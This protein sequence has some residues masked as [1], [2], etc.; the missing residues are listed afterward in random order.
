MLPSF[1]YLR[2]TSLDEAVRQ[3]ALPGA[4]AHAGGTDLLG[5]LR[6]R[7]LAAERVVS[8]SAIAALRG[9]SP[10]A[11]GGLRI[12]ALVTLAELAADARIG[13]RYPTL[14]HAAAA[15]ASPQLRNQGT[16]GGNL[17]QR[18]RCWYYRGEFHCARKGGDT[19]FAIGGENQYHAIFGGDACVY[20]HPS[21]TA[22]ALVALGALVRIVGPGGARVVPVERFF[23]L[24]AQDHTRETVLNAG[25]LV[26]EIVLPA[27]AKG[28]RG[29]YRKVRAR[30]AWDFALVG[31][32]L[33]LQLEG[34]TVRH[35]D[36]VLSGVAPAPW[37]VPAAEKA[38]VGR[39][40]DARSARAAGEAASRGATPLAHN[41]Y[42]VDIVRGAVE[43]ALL[44]LV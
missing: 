1:S 44:T 37:R 13:E 7:V 24:P 32:A 26:S 22:P 19:C 11:E 36:V 12:G 39:A 30:G 5:C 9:I 15:A 43:D 16:I 14:A 40:L 25:E 8:L 29:G 31:V 6:D 21:D 33:A 41:D 28:M 2:P 38:L 23:L 17:C 42:T 4:R 27:P 3:L 34:K 35:A 20:V 18:P 10:T